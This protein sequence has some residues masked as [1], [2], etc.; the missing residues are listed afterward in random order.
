MAKANRK[1]T[2]DQQMTIGF[3][4]LIKTLEDMVTATEELMP[5]VAAS[6]ELTVKITRMYKKAF[7]LGEKYAKL[8]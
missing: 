7:K 8:R 4:T 2:K 1:S 3:D 6:L 5:L